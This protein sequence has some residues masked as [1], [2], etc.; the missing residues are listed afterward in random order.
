[1]SFS[2][3]KSSKR[4]SGP[5][6]LQ[7]VMRDAK[8]GLGGREGGPPEGAV[9]VVQARGPHGQLAREAARLLALGARAHGV[10]AAAVRGVAHH[11][12][13]P[14]PRPLRATCRCIANFNPYYQE[15]GLHANV[16][17]LTP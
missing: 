1:M 9:G 10:A 12:H 4:R 17:K 13:L 2:V 7:D 16:T 6:A 15:I 5:A 8:L 3:M 11:V 14:L